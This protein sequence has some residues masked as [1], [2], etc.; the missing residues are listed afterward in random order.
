[1]DRREFLASS[2]AALA[3]LALGGA[4][5]PLFAKKA[6]R[7]YNMILLGDTLL[8]FHRRKWNFYF[9]QLIR[10]ALSFIRTSFLD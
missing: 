5:N 10:F 9:F 2:A 1:M 6:D 7:D 8:F 3:G 4:S